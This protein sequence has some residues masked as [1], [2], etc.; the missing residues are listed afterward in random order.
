MAT[1]VFPCGHERPANEEVCSLCSGAL[2]TLIP[3]TTSVKD[4]LDHYSASLNIESVSKRRALTLKHLL[5]DVL[6]IPG[7]YV[8]VTPSTNE[9]WL[10]KI[11]TLRSLKKMRIRR[12]ACTA[13]S[14]PIENESIIASKNVFR[15]FLID[16]VAD[17]FTA[18]RKGFD[19]AAFIVSRNYRS[20]IHDDYINQW[21]RS[22]KDKAP[23]KAL[24]KGVTVA[25]SSLIALGLAALI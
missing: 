19:T 13:V 25:V 16:N 4:D 24:K 9:V 1:I 12:S 21:K 22:T 3:S 20:S 18:D 7:I 6:K 17:I 10:L 14:I 11:K 8:H 15:D 5:V 23:L 2:S